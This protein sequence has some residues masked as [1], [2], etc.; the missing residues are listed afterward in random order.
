MQAL[1]DLAGWDLAVAGLP[2]D[3]L[4][5]SAQKLST[6]LGEVEALLSGDIDV[7][8]LGGALDD[9]ATAVAGL[10]EIG[11][12]WTPT[13]GL[14]EDLVA[15]F[16]S[17]LLGRVL[18]LAL[19]RQPILRSVLELVGVLRY[20]ATTAIA[21]TSGDA[22]R[23]AGTRPGLD[24][25]QLGRLVA[26]PAAAVRDRFGAAGGTDRQPP[27]AVADAIFPF[28]AD[29]LRVIG[30]R[31]WYGRSGEVGGT[32]DAAAD[33]LSAHTLRVTFA[34][35]AEGDFADARVDVAAAF[36]DDG[37][38]RILSVVPDVTLSAKVSRAT[39]DATAQVTGAAGA[40]A[41]RSDSVQFTDSSDSSLALTAA[42]ERPASAT[43]I[44]SLGGSSGLRFAVAG[45][46]AAVTL[47]FTEAGADFELTADAS[48]IQFAVAPGGDSFLAAILPANGLGTTFD[49]DVAWS[50]QHGLTLGGSAGLRITI[51]IGSKLG[52]LS[53]DT[54]AIAV[55]GAPTGLT[56]MAT[57]AF[58]AQIGPVAAAVSG[59]GITAELVASQSGGA[60]GALALTVAPAPPT[61][62]AV[63]I[64][65][66]EA[67][68][69]GYLALDPA[70][71]T[72]AGA[73][74]LSLLTLSLAAVGLVVTRLPGG[75]PGYSMLALVSVRFSPPIEIGFG[76]AIDG[77]GGLLGINRTIAI[78]PLRA[79]LQKGSLDSVLFPSDVMKNPQKVV[80][81]LEQ[82]FPSAPQQYLVGPMVEILWGEDAMF[83]ASVGVFIEFPKPTRVTIVGQFRLALPTPQAAVAEIEMDVLGEI[84]FTA[85]LVAIDLALRNSRIAAF[86]LTGQGALRASWG[87]EAA[88]LLSLGGWNPSFTPPASFPP[89]S[90]LALALSQSANPLIRF[91]AYLAI[92]SNTIQLGA[93]VDLSAS[94]DIPVI[95]TFGI[96]A[97]L[98]FDALI[99]L[100][101]FGFVVDI[102]ASVALTWNKKP[103]LAVMLD[104]TLSGPHPWHAVGKATFTCFGSHSVQFQFT[105]GDAT[106][107]PA[108]STVDGTAAL[109]GEL[110]KDSN[111]SAQ[112]PP[113][114]SA[115]AVTG[116]A[117]QTG[118][119]LVHPLGALTFR[120]KTMPLD[121]QITR[122]ANVPLASG[123]T[124]YSITL[125][126]AGDGTAAV[127]FVTESFAPSQFLSLTD[128]QKLSRPSFEQHDAGFAIAPGTIAW[129]DGYTT[130]A[131]A[132]VE[133]HVL[134]ADPD[135]HGGLVAQAP[136]VSSVRRPVGTALLARGRVTSAAST[137]A[138]RDTGP[139]GDAA[140]LPIAVVP[141]TYAVVD[142]T[143][144]NPW[145]DDA[146]R[147]ATYTVADEQRQAIGVGAQVVA[148]SSAQ[149]DPDRP[150]AGLD[151][152]AYYLLTSV[153][154]GQCLAVLG[155]STAAGASVVQQPAA[156]AGS[157]FWRFEPVSV[158]TY[159][160]VAEHSGMALAADA[161]GTANGTPVI[162][163][164]SVGGFNQ[165]WRPVRVGP[166]RYRIELVN[167]GRCL[168]VAGQ[169]VSSGATV[170]LWDWWGGANQQWQ[171][172]RVSEPLL[173]HQW[174]RERAFERWQQEGRPL[175]TSA[176][177][178]W[179]HASVDILTPIIAREAEARYERRGRGPGRDQED[180]YAAVSEVVGLVAQAGN[181]PDELLELS[182]QTVSEGAVTVS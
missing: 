115:G 76:F 108:P 172:T 61:G 8:K 116:A 84:D 109:L 176:L 30:A 1:V 163:W 23:A 162:Q 130:E 177:P 140:Q 181:W 68:G 93:N 157:E 122:I 95:G 21:T 138:T 107:L 165:E 39:W 99:E 25:N 121:I 153:N 9:V 32:V 151:P 28:V 20:E 150:L 82:Y 148:T 158:G 66:D 154:S 125:A 26:D 89:L 54:A 56:G 51:P 141:R 64:Q 80:S 4:T 83:T 167:A 102:H 7:V 146:S 70:T 65:A 179:L 104:L 96:A 52:P 101:P 46:K 63:S 103:F 132:N 137:R 142:R 119:V 40:I 12:N 113:T 43:P 166:A 74:D 144:L 55:T 91:E 135:G 87:Q 127:S 60:L 128:D 31:A 170:Q 131:S 159:R 22:V 14:P 168:D 41:I 126:V 69:A 33:A 134:V 110:A 156:D 59:L 105:T 36:G 44:A 182:I 77:I 111:W 53:L 169:S 50:R 34:G 19:G 100:D 97:S 48:A 58:S 16:L 15:S 155:G 173:W 49:L 38:Y 6:S 133:V 67:S 24:F 18:V 47:T 143:L 92:T 62:I 161:I 152:S 136:P 160:V 120:Q 27:E 45:A 57:V 2:I 5:A 118:A 112:L 139:S 78:D 71:G 94:L 164:S 42:I 149:A 75:S 17:D 86:T 11:A 145:S 88:F 117:A 72:Y 180:W 37:T 90:R 79:G 35:Q 73:V 98:G 175:W 178:D 123:A 147:L 3:R 13:N 124:T 29:L 81:D 10:G 171:L 129:P 106:A 174:V 85:K 114:A